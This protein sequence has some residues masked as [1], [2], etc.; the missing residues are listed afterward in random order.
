MNQLKIALYHNTVPKTLD[1]VDH[2]KKLLNQNNIE[3]DNQNPDTI[4]T[5]GGDGT[6]LGAFHNYQ[7]LVDT[8]P[9]VG[10][11][12]GHLGFYTDWHADDLDN[13]V[14]C[15]LN[16][17][18]PYL[19]ACPLLEVSITYVD[20][21]NEQLLALNESTIR[22]NNGRTQIANVYIED[23]FF[24]EFRGDGL[25]FST[26]TGSTAYNKSIGG[27][28]I[29][30]EIKAFQMAEIASLNN[31]SFR[32]LTSPVI[33]PYDRTIRVDLKT[34]ENTSLTVDQTV[35]TK[36]IKSLAFTL[37]KHTMKIASYHPNNFWD[38]VRHAFIG[39]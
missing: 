37:S 5:V 4:V 39:E 11:H 10:I 22:K 9:F 27:A 3:I 20:G 19:F 30:P 17:P 25:C 26:P 33:I 35:I 38:R 36:P 18:E 2:L 24:E 13:F 23:R 34:A 1:T 28:I 12:T 16:E 31:T 21:Q 14:E 6:L 32:T 7:N 29:G 15:L 8:T